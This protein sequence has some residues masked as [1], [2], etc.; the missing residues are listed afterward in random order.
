MTCRVGWINKNYSSDG[1]MESASE[2]LSF[3]YQFTTFPLCEYRAYA[4][5][6]KL[7]KQ[8]SESFGVVRG[9]RRDV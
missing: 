5:E 7:T 2:E 1:Y 4:D 6:Y 3:L 9:G 8:F